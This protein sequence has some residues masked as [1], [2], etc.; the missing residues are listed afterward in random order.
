[1][2]NRV[3]GMAFYRP[4]M[5][6]SALDNTRVLTRVRD[7][8]GGLGLW[9]A[10]VLVREAGDGS[11]QRGRW[12]KAQGDAQRALGQR[13]ERHEPPNGGDGNSNPRHFF[14]EAHRRV[15]FYHPRW[16]LRCQCGSD[17]RACCASPWALFRH[18]LRGF[19]RSCRGFIR[20]RRRF[21]R[22]FRGFVRSFIAPPQK[23]SQPSGRAQ[24]E[25]V[26]VHSGFLG[27]FRR[28]KKP[29]FHRLQHVWRAHPL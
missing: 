13:T 22:F 16:G 3:D 20:A 26:E 7:G 4:D 8:F 29:C 10:G 19:I 18:P 28:G 15:R 2:S 11:P 23:L 1:M 9:R 27:A 25:S 14:R 6:V 5:R 21:I 24:K 12:I 17:P